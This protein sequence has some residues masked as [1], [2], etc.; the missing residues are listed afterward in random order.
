KNILSRDSTININILITKFK[1][2]DR[3]NKLFLSSLL[4][5]IAIAI[6][7]LRVVITPNILI[8]ATIFEY[9]PNC[10]GEYNLVITGSVRIIKSWPI[11]VPVIKVITFLKKLFIYIYFPQSYINFERS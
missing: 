7:Y 3:Y 9:S 6:S 11:K 10:S 1:I 2:K 5:V 4:S 8:I